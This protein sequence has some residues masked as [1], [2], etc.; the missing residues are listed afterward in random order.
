M[1]PDR[2]MFR[3]GAILCQ[4][5]PKIPASTSPDPAVPK[6][7]L[8]RIIGSGPVRVLPS[9]THA[10]IS[11]KKSCKPVFRKVQQGWPRDAGGNHGALRG[12]VAGHKQCVCI[13]NQRN[14]YSQIALRRHRAPRGQPRCSPVPF[15]ND[16]TF[17]DQPVRLK[18]RPHID[19]AAA[20]LSAARPATHRPSIPL[21]PPSTSTCW[22]PFVAGARRL[23]MLVDQILLA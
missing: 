23:A 8:Q 19:L 4:S 15:R 13:Q 11:S 5:A 6:A 3:C 10:A 16:R 17:T 21:H 2:C 7:L 12:G 1:Q 18:I 20:G 14:L 22:V 9:K